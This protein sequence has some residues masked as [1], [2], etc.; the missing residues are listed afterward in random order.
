[1]ILIVV[2]FSFYQKD[3]L[4]TTWK[5]D[6]TDFVLRCGQETRVIPRI[7]QMKMHW[8]KSE[9]ENVRLTEAGI[10]KEVSARVLSLSLSLSCARALGRNNGGELRAGQKRGIF[11]H[12]FE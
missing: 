6:R 2:R 3:T 8:S 9:K 11:Q 4:E 12:R 5:I 1:M 7:L 10:S